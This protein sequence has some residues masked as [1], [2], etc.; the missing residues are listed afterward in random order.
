MTSRPSRIVATVVAAILLVVSVPASAAMLTLS[1]QG[2][3]TFVLNAGPGTPNVHRWTSFTASNGTNLNG[4]ALNP[5]GTWTVDAGTWTVNANRAAV[6]ST[7]NARIRTDA[8][9]PNAAVETV[10]TFPIATRRAGVILNGSGANY[11]AVEW[12]N[13]TATTGQIRLRRFAPTASTL[14]TVTVPLPATARLRVESFS[15]TIQVFVDG[16]LVLSH[17]L[18]A[19]NV[20]LFKSATATRFG[21]YASSDANTRFDDFH[22][23]IP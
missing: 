19:A 18:S 3:G 2:I 5:S 10:L 7:A 14:A 8:P 20:T 21:L 17:T 23:D 6:T 22:V 13:P 4:A 11:L 12:R 15:N 9:G 1:S 16:T